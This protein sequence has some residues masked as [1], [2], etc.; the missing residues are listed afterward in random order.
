MAN[1]TS[2]AERKRRQKAVNAVL[3]AGYTP[4][5][6]SGGEGSA[7]AQAAVV[8][9]IHRTTIFSWV[10]FETMMQRTG[11]PHYL[12][13]WSLYK[14]AEGPAPDLNAAEAKEKERLT[15]Q[16]KAL[17][18]ELRSARKRISSLENIR[19]NLFGLVSTPLNPPRWMTEPR[20]NDGFPG[21]PILNT[22][23][24]QYGEVIRP[25][26][27]QGINAYNPEIAR[28][29]YFALIDKTIYLTQE[30][31]VAPRY[32]GITVLRNGDALSGNI[33]K[34]LRET[35]SGNALRQMHECTEMEIAG[36]E[37]LSEHFPSVAVY[38]TPG[39]HGRDTEK[40]QSKH[41]AENNYEYWMAL[42][43]ERHF[44]NN[45]KFKFYLPESGDALF[46]LHGWTF[47]AT[48]GDRI[49]SR[50]GTGFIGPSATVAR[51]MQRLR[52][53][54]M[55][56]NVPIDYVLVGHFHNAI[57]L[58][59]GFGNGTLA[60]FSE[61]ARD[62]RFIP[63]PASQWLLFVHPKYGISQRWQIQLQG[64]LRI[65]VEGLAGR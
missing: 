53:Y 11:K 10:E 60:G 42:N 39:N 41:Y 49:G 52:Q 64:R 22:S 43:I 24:F 17:G 62:G 34:E 23:D 26:E 12:P 48:H 51:G 8:L 5:G 16:N 3:K 32:N 58:E 54:Y 33:H 18:D 44:K 4:P 27:L 19:E 45:P 30:Y 36:L 14:P 29:R 2:V 47:L 6:V 63:R 9:N 61:Y 65:D 1:P 31:Q 59:Y 15:R 37:K 56:L 35:N 20:I 21:D 13:D 55:Q 57:E 40:P 7:A 28:K 38:S 25:G 46:Q 50:G